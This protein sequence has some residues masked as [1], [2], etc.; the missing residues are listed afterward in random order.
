M[1]TRILTFSDSNM[2][3]S[4]WRW[5][6][7]LEDEDGG[8][9]RLS[10]QQVIT[11][12]EA[13]VIEPVLRL[14][15]GADVYSALEAML[16]EA[17]NALEENELASIAVKIA[18]L[19]KRLADQ[20]ERGPKLLER[21]DAAAAK[22]AAAHSH[23]KLAQFRSTIDKYVLKF[24]DAPMRFAGGSSYGTQRKWAKSF[25]EQYVIE[26]GLLPDGSHQIKVTVGGAG[27]SGATHDFSELKLTEKIIID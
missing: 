1:K 4:S 15:R 23:A 5:N 12:E 6:F 24:S 3:R 11:D 9:Y 19:D 8:A 18:K 16:S 2:A 10:C 17:G 25:I 21:R 20:F 7:Y 22:R 13:M 27:Y 26:N 14:R